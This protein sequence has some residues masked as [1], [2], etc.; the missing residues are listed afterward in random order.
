VVEDK[1]GIPELGERDKEDVY[2]SAKILA[3]QGVKGG[4]FSTRVVCLPQ[5]GTEGCTV[6]RRRIMLVWKIS[7]GLDYR[8]PE[9]CGEGELLCQ[10]SGC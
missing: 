2:A 10:E 7:C 8:T 4:P 3:A 6:L 5:Q 1:F 9:Y